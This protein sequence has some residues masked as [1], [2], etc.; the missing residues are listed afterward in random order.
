MTVSEE[1]G[2]EVGQC[3]ALE[4]RRDISVSGEKSII[5]LST[6]GISVNSEGADTLCTH[7]GGIAPSIPVAA[8]GLV[9]LAGCDLFRK[10]NPHDSI[11]PI[12]W[13]VSALHEAHDKQ[14]N[15]FS[16]RTRI[17]W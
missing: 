12:E 16:A 2:K 10:L 1:R 6:S 8:C 3:D 13:C 5:S 11:S 7:T 9:A 4:E 15:P 17:D 14:G